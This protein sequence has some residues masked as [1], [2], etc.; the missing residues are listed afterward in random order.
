MTEINAFPNTDSPNPAESVKPAPGSR[1]FVI[2]GIFDA[3]RD[4]VFRA[5]TEQEHLSHWFGPKGFTIPV[6][7]L[8]LIPGGAFHYCMRATNGTEMW[9]KWTFREIVSPDR[10]DFVNT[11]SNK[12]GNLTRH[13][14]VPK[15]PLEILTT[16]TFTELEGMTIVKI[17]WLPINATAAERTTFDE[18]HE[19]MTEGWTGTFDQLRTYLTTL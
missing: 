16:A 10:I 8:N 17:A 5:W 2:T 4:L 3:P 18:M 11:F 15:W 14:Y 1:E 13:P 9:G 19:A 12:H 7:F 6:S